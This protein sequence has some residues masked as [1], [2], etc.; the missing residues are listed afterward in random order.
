MIWLVPS[1]ALAALALVSGIRLIAR[2]R[3]KRD[4]M[5]LGVAIPRLLVSLF[6][7]YL[8][9][10]DIDIRHEALIRLGLALILASDEIVFIL[11]WIGKRLWTHR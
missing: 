3:R 9:F 10:A 8:V 5:I 7:L 1:W 6:C 4:L 11:D 2:S